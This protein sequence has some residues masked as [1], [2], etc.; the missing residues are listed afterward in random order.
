MTSWT[1]DRKE[2]EKQPVGLTVLDFRIRSVTSRTEDRKEVFLHLLAS[3][4]GHWHHGRGTE[5]RKE[6]VNSLTVLTRIRTDHS[7]NALY[8]P[9]VFS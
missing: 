2:E 7:P 6:K 9:G 3:G 8:A 5:D 4:S 1:E